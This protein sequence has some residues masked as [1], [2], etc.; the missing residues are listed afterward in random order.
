MRFAET[1]L[2]GAYVIE[3]E[4]RVD[5]R[6]FF[7]RV[8]CTDELA[9]H[10]LEPHVAQINDSL[11]RE[12]GTLRGLHYQL[13]PAAETK[14]VRCIQG[15][16]WDVILDLRRESATFGRWFGIE[17]TAEN[18]TMLYVPRGFAHGFVTLVPDTEI[19]YVVSHPYA[20]E[21]ERG[22]RWND[23]AFSIDWPVEPVVISEKDRSLPDFDAAYHL[24]G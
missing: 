10:G 9:R 14:L 15:A 16:V 24:G 11:S 8:F 13:P 6:G 12:A 1:P 5:E 21:Y 20:P 4:P 3:P 22:I 2:P 19:V 7:A 17:L 23:P 18:R